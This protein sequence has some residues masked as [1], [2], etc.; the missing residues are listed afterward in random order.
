M[1]YKVRNWSEYN[2]GLQQQRGLTFWLEEKVIAQ[3]LQG[4]KHR[5]GRASQKYSDIAIAT[6]ETMK[7]V[8]GLSGR[9]TKGFLSS[10]FTSMEIDLPVPEYSTVSKR[11][12]KLQ[13]ELPV[14]PKQGKVHVVVD[15]TGVKVYG[16]GEW[17]T[18]QH[19]VN[20]KR[21]WRKLHLGVSDVNLSFQDPPQDSDKISV[22]LV[23]DQNSIR[24]KLQLSLASESG[25]EIIGSA[26]DGESAIAQVKD[27]HPDIALIDIEMPV[28]NGL[29]ATE[30]IKQNFLSTNVIILSSYDSNEYID[31]ALKA[32]AK[33]YL[34]KNTPTT[35][36]VHAIRYVHKGYL[37]IGPGIFEKFNPAKIAP[38]PQDIE[39]Q[40]KQLQVLESQPPQPLI[41][42]TFEAAGELQ[43]QQA[44]DS[45][46]LVVNHHS[47]SLSATQPLPL[48][49]INSNEWSSLT[50]E[51]I[52]TL[53]QI[54]TRGLLYFL[55]VF[56]GILLPWS[57]LS[58][59]DET[60]SAKGKLEP[61]GKVF[62]VDAPV[63]G[64]IAKVLVKEGQLVKNQQPL[65]TL[66]SEPVES[67]LQQVKTQTAGQLKELTQLKL[68]QNQL[69]VAVNTQKQQNQAQLFEKQA[70][71]NQARQNIQ[72]N[73]TARH[74]ASIAHSEAL[75]EVQRYQ[76]AK[77]QGIV[78]EIQVVEKQ[79]LVREK[80]RLLEQ[81]ISDTQQAQ[82]RLI[83]QE[84]SYQSLIYS[85]NLAVLE[86][87][88]Q[89][90]EL[91]K[92]IGTLKFQ[93]K[94]NK[95]QI[96][97]LNYQLKQRTVK[98]PAS[99]SIFQLPAQK[100]G[101]VLEPGA[102]VAEIAPKQ[103]SLI[104]KAQM[105]P[106][107]SGSLERGMLVKLK[108]DAYPFQDYGIVEGKLINISPTTKV[109]ETAEGKVE[110][111]ELEIKLNQNYIQAKNKRVALRPG[112]TATAEVVVRQRRLIDFV[113]D[114]FKKL[115]KDGLEL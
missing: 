49:Q 91:A 46:S 114:P 36:I 102:L 104:L 80:K 82:L 107:E 23:D 14:V 101:S 70:Q 54:W 42:A 79:D 7:L 96:N 69:V 56:I 108:F 5:K 88:K 93:I 26:V 43:K 83:E 61:K 68:L 59:I 33:G 64:T 1:S 9:Q 55:I 18:R 25:L 113:L 50:K 63:A 27:L 99:G 98:A 76:E 112:Q 10:I 106:P 109:V 72:Y 87:E 8:Y 52:E 48:E 115:N 73:Q 81:V 84:E 21:T 24:Q 32:G 71:L 30:V 47:R 51:L 74:L 97:A 3:W 103:S 85:G 28:M 4:N 41:A 11:K 77:Q 67:E 39:Q 92:Q 89:L 110:N 94:E 2:K 78:S 105:S 12:G 86:S 44:N 45:P 60:G 16:E 75:K 65:L 37:Q 13:V 62:T 38:Q 53:P 111:Y 100:T 66:E 31:Q 57:M 34:L 90:Q 40:H 95:S 15:L 58:K 29:E 20:N 17:K 35:E 19:R 6:F 22:L